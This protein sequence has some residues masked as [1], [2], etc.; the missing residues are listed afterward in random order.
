MNASKNRY[1]SGSKLILLTSILLAFFWSLAL[2]SNLY[3]FA[4]TGAIFEILWQPMILLLF[5]LPVLS[6]LNIAK[7][8]KGIHSLSF[9][10]LL[11]QAGL[12]AMMLFYPGFD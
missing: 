4:F 8:K 9:Y 1:S 3:H 10:S 11:I 7:E 6:I 12:I 2:T 5:V